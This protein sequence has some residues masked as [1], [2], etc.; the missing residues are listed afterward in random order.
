MTRVVQC[1]TCKKDVEWSEQN[2]YRP[3]CSKRCKLIDLGE[4]AKESFA[5]PVEEQDQFIDLDKESEPP[6]N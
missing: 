6:E 5:I 1:P 2:P 4:W 3:F